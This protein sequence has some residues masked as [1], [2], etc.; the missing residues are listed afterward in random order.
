[1]AAHSSILTWENPWTEEPGGLQSMGSQGAGHDWETNSFLSYKTEILLLDIYP[2]EM[3]MYGHSKT[4]I[5]LAAVFLISQNW[6]QF[7]LFTNYWKAK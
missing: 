2:R 1:M 5:F 3:K 4:C 6:K 7:K